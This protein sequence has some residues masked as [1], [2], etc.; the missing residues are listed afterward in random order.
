[1]MLP[2]GKRFGH[3]D[4]ELAFAVFFSFFLHAAVVF[5]VLFVHFS[6]FPKAVVPLAYQVKLVGLP[7]NPVSAPAAP[8]KK[9]PEAA[10]VMPKKKSM[11][12]AVKPSR[13]MKKAAAKKEAMPELGHLHKKPALADRENTEEEV[14]QK[15][16][17]VPAASSKGAQVPGVMSE[18]VAVTPQQD[19][20]DIWYLNN[21]SLKIRR[22]W[23]PPPNSMGSLARVIFTIN[24]SGRVISIDLDEDH[25]TGSDAFKLAARRAIRLSDPFPHLPDDFY[26]PSIEF[27]VDL[28]P[29]Q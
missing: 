26:K 2:S 28:I 12:P 25:S 9:E 20:K 1:M 23:T 18:G 14:P 11:P 5:V 13:T 8:A 27:S 24:R 29:E 16:P 19:F 15:S 7:E 10:P 22:F 3:S 4:N 17:A 6:V 21:M